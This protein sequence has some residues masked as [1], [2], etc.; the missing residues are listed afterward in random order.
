MAGTCHTTLPLPC[1][2]S[3]GFSLHAATRVEATDR[4]S[5]LTVE[6]GQIVSAWV[7]ARAPAPFSGPLASCH[8]HLTG[9]DSTN[10]V[11]D[12]DR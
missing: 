9:E 8:D 2:A 10:A 7:S 11:P 1:F 4:V 6:D 3:R 5:S 12:T